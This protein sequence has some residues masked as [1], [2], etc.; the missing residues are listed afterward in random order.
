M[1]TNEP[2]PNKKPDKIDIGL[3]LLAIAW[4]YVSVMVAIVRWEQISGWD[5]AG[6]VIGIITAFGY[7]LKLRPEKTVIHAFAAIVGLLIV[8]MLTMF[9]PKLMA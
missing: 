5:L 8:V 1:R 9:L 2:D 6:I 3:T 4:I 7:W